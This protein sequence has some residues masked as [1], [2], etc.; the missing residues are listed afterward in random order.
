MITERNVP[1]GAMTPDGGWRFA[2]CL[3]CQGAVY[4]REDGNLFPHQR[5]VNTG[6]GEL[7]HCEGSG[8]TVPDVQHVGPEGE[9]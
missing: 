1:A 3:V 9:R 2:V 5:R 6:A 8:Q 7:V 4:A